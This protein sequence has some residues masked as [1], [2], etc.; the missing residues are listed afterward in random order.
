VNVTVRYA[1]QARDVAGLA[2]ETAEA[3]TLAELLRGLAE[4][5][6][7]LK[8]LLLRDDGSPRPSLVLAI[9]DAQARPD[10]SLKEGDVVTILTP[11]AGG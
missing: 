8:P 6:P 9:G 4:R 7:S 10:A 5:R 2:S 11:I 3:A 1:G